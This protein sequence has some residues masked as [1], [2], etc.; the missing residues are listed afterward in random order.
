MSSAASDVYKRQVLS[1]AAA[2]QDSG[3]GTVGI[4]RVSGWGVSRQKAEYD[5]LVKIAKETGMSLMEIK[6]LIN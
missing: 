1:R 6:K 5:D 3:I 4:K 2:Q